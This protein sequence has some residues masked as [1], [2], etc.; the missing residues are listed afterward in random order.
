LHAAPAPAGFSFALRR[1]FGTNLSLPVLNA[2][3]GS[4][5]KA[6]T[7]DAHGVEAATVLL[8]EH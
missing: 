8:K 7:G 2:S 6:N 4:S 5:S 1:H 3:A